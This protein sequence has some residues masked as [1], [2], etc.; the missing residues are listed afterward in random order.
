VQPGEQLERRA[1]DGVRD[2]V[3]GESAAELGVER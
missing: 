3:I 2:R 1:A